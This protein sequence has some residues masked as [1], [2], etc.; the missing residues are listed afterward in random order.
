MCKLLRCC[1]NVRNMPCYCEYFLKYEWMYLNPQKNILRKKSNLMLQC[2]YT[3]FLRNSCESF[4]LN[5]FNKL[6]FLQSLYCCVYVD[7]GLI[8]GGLICL[9]QVTNKSCFAI[10]KKKLNLILQFNVHTC[11]ENYSE[12]INSTYINWSNVMSVYF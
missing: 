10:S 9:L 6:F 3:A 11:V 8:T 2:R 4:F 12:Y 5:H 7:D 1:F